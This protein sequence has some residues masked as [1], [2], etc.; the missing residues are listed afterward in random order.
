MAKK[1][2]KLTDAKYTIKG[3]RLNFN[4]KC[5]KHKKYTGK[6][7]PTGVCR[8]CWQVYSFEANAR[9][10]VQALTDKLIKDAADETCQ[11]ADA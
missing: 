8:G 11:I 10:L 5:L 3:E 4:L 6:M 7:P 2:E 1:V 9:L